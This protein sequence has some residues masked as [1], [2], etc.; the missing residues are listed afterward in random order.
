MVD[1]HLPRY[2]PRVNYRRNEPDKLPSELKHLVAELFSLKISDPD[3]IANDA[4]LFGGS[5]GLD[6]LDALE[7]AMCIEEEFGLTL[8]NREESQRAFSSISSLTHF[9]LTQAQQNP[10]PL[11]SSIPARLSSQVLTSSSMA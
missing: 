2:T 10:V 11:L 9:I 7:L 6:S 1:L 5:L 3:S 8:S 4:P